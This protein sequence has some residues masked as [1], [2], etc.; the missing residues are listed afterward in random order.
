MRAGNAGK[1]VRLEMEIL[2]SLSYISRL[3]RIFM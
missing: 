1:D 2:S 3:S